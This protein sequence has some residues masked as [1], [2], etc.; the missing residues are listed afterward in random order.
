MSPNLPY[1]EAFKI[2]SSP[3]KDKR[4]S[5]SSLPSVEDSFPTKLSIYDANPVYKEFWYFKSLCD[6]QEKFKTLE[7]KLEMVDFLKS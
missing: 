7:S 3:N 4:A 5:S 1:S 6:L 2:S